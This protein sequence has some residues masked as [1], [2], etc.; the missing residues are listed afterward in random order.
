VDLHGDGT[1]VAQSCVRHGVVSVVVA[2]QQS[3]GHG[4]AGK[5][6]LRDGFRV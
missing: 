1:C 3:L 5:T 2:S 4:H 6:A